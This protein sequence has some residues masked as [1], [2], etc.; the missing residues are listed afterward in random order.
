MGYRKL[1]PRP[2]GMPKKVFLACFELVV[3]H[4]S[5]RTIPKCLENGLFLDPKWVK[6][7]FSYNDRGSFGVHKRAVK[8]GQLRT[9]NGSKQVKTM[10]SQK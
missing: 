9:T 3:A 6:M 2:H 8:M 7:C 5:L 1:H 10:V 4:F